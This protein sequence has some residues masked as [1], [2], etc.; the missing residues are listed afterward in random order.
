MLE[1]EHITHNLTEGRGADPAK[2]SRSP[3]ISLDPPSL[4]LSFFLSLF[5]SLA[6]TRKRSLSFLSVL[7]NYV[8]IITKQFDETLRSRSY[9]FI[10]FCFPPIHDKKETIKTRERICLATR[11]MAITTRYTI[12]GRKIRLIIDRP[13]NSLPVARLSYFVS[14]SRTF[15]FTYVII[16]LANNVIN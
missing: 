7:S 2:K 1:N 3:I 9:I 4:S 10:P 12:L 8:D 13:S 14:H 11:R 5:L 6:R 15:F 16:S